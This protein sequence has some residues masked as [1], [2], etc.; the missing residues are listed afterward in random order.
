MSTA[1]V[2]GARSTTMK[3]LGWPEI[4]RFAR[5]PA[6]LAGVSLC[7]LILFFAIRE[8]IAEPTND[9]MGAGVVALFIG[10]CSMLAS[11]FLTRWMKGADEILEATPT[12]RPRRTAALCATCPDRRRHARSTA[13]RAQLP[14]R[15][16]D[17]HHTEVRRQCP[18]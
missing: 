11:S 15:H 1:S 12:T 9:R 4:R 2:V 5:H 3:P 16:D 17:S 8:A 14:G 18:H 7:S 10:V 6:F 13:C